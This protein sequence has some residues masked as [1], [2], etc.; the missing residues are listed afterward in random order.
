[1]FRRHDAGK[2]LVAEPSVAEESI[3]GDGVVKVEGINAKPGRY[4]IVCHVAY[5]FLVEVVFTLVSDYGCWSVA[6]ANSIRKYLIR[7]NYRCSRYN[8]HA[9]VCQVSCDHV[10]NIFW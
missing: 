10:S 5:V 6:D 3:Q 9:F 7:N 1:M 2:D 4:N 8:W